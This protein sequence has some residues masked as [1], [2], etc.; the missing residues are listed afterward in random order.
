MGH[1]LLSIFTRRCRQRG[2]AALAAPLFL[3]LAVGCAPREPIPLP[4]RP[5]IAYGE[6]RIWQVDREGLASSYIFGTY[7]ISD[8][9]VLDVPDAVEEAFVK[10]EFAAF[11][12]DYGPDA[13]TFE[14]DMDLVK[15]P[16]GTTLRSIVGNGT[17][18]DLQFIMRSRDMRPR[19]DLKP[20]IFWD[21]LGGP[22]AGF[23]TSD[24]ESVR[25]RPVLDDWLQA[26]A[27]DEGKTVVG[28]ETQEE[29]F[30]KYDTIPMPVQV[31]LLK[32]TVEHYHSRRSGAPMVQSYVDGDMAML[33]AFWQ[34]SLSWYAP[35]TAATL[36]FRI[37]TNRNRIMVERMLPLMEQGPT[38]VAVGAAHVPGEEGILRLLERQGFT[39]TTLY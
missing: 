37:V 34:E 2:R 5:D 36:D 12:Y 6:G 26:R 27:R 24:D 21:Y 17:F 20:W 3:L 33:M 22:R 25:G 39:V 10:S 30:R 7:H 1:R 29:G 8:P 14:F 19:N 15:L 18:G 31:D 16:E 4:E 38:F 35:E 11:E 23:Y 13:E 28:L 32:A 9:R